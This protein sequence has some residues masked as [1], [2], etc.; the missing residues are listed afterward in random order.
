MSQVKII[1]VCDLDQLT[2]NI[3]KNLVLVRPSKQ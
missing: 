2:Q 3:I 1:T